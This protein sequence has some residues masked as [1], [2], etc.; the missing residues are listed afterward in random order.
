MKE[1]ELLNV[2][3]KLGHHITDA[4]SKLP[5]NK[6]SEQFG[7]DSTPDEALKRAVESMIEKLKETSRSQS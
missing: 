6:I 7:N 4:P 5:A 3:R 2:V 1:S